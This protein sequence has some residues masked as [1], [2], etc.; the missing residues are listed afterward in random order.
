MIHEAAVRLKQAG[1]W[2]SKTT[3]GHPLD[4]YSANEFEFMAM[5]VQT[6][7][8]FPE[9]EGYCAPRPQAYCN[10]YIKYT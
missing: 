7:H 4:R 6:W 1:I 3:K 9:W 5:A 2:M 8:G 10:V